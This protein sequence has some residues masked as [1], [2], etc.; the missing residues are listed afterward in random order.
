MNSLELFVIST[1]H[2]RALKGVIVENPLNEIFF[3]S[4]LLEDPGTTDEK[5]TYFFG[6]TVQYIV[7]LQRDFLLGISLS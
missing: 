7:G 4:T 1:I 3:C 5:T 6:I 2:E